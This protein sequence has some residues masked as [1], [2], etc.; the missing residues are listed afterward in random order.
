VPEGADPDEIDPEAT[1]PDETDEMDPDETE[2]DD[3]PEGRR[4]AARSVTPHAAAPSVARRAS[5][6]ARILAGEGVRSAFILGRDLGRIGTPHIRTPPTDDTSQERGA[7]AH[8]S[9]ILS[10]TA[11]LA[12]FSFAA[13]G[14]GKERVR[15]GS[16]RAND[17]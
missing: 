13:V 3:A 12:A 2:P 16:T 5:Q 11:G 8:F 10:R 14:Q 15:S 1:D 4:I 9:E 6:R 7:L 17:S